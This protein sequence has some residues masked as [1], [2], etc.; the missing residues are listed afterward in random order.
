[1]QIAVYCT[2]AAWNPPHLNIFEYSI[3]SLFY[4]AVTVL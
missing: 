3:L 2:G 1:M 4:C